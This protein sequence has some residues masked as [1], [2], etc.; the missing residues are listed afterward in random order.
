MYFCE[1]LRKMAS[2]LQQQIERVCAKTLVLSEK[3]TVTRASLEEARAQITELK[4]K[5]MARD[6]TIQDLKA[7]VEYLSVASVIEHDAGSVEASR[8]IIADLLK[9]VD[10]CI[11]DLVE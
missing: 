1:N 9:E 11:R 4:A 6:R 8:A 5:I 7:K 3:Y 10:R 2:D